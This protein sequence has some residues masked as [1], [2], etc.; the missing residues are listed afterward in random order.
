MLRFFLLIKASDRQFCC[1]VLLKHEIQ[2]VNINR[3]GEK[4]LS[5][6]RSS[7]REKIATLTSR[8]ITGQNSASHSHGA[9]SSAFAAQGHLG[10]AKLLML[11][12]EFL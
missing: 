4:R 8:H 2:L 1:G 12:W 9:P 10:S 3:F 6:I 7:L 11:Q 5:T